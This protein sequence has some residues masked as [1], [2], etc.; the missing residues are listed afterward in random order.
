MDTDGASKNSDKNNPISVDTNNL[1]DVL[2][3]KKKE[4]V[5]MFF[6]RFQQV[7]YVATTHL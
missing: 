3:Q 6:E 2:R 4:T 5:R 7:T 1:Q